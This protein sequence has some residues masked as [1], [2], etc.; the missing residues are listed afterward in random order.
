MQPNNITSL[1]EMLEQMSTEQLDAMLN[2][3]LRGESVDGNSVRMILR[4]LREREK[5]EPVEITPEIQKA[6]DE[7]RQNVA[8]LENQHSGRARK[9][10]IRAASA[11]AV[12][13][14]LISVVPRQAEA[15]SLFERLARWTEDVVEFFS[16][17]DDESR[18]TNYE[19]KT[20]DPGL[21][22][23]YDAVVELGI[24]EPVVP[25]WLPDGYELSECSVRTTDVKKFLYARFL[26]KDFEITYKINLYDS[27]PSHFYHK[28]GTDLEKIEI[29]GTTYNIMK[30]ED[31]WV[32]IW[33]KNNIEC[34]IYVDC[35]EDILYKILGSIYVMEEN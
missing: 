10:L 12:L 15:D 17:D 29:E 27:E 22:Q 33:T 2:K 4:I 11:A 21:Q 8:S 35:Q 13:I 25:M 19:F 6:W 7:Y 20:E 32:V 28:D 34:S 14:L 18:L 5:D 30:N 26:D 9:W 3:E 24:T 16:S 23:V 1:R 31:L